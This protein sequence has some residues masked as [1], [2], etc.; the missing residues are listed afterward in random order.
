MTTNSAL[1]IILSCCN[2]IAGASAWQVVLAAR[3]SKL[4]LRLIQET[5]DHCY[6]DLVPCRYNGSVRTDAPGTLPGSVSHCYAWIELCSPLPMPEH[7]QRPCKSIYPGSLP[8]T[9]GSFPLLTGLVQSQ[10]GQSDLS[11]GK[12]YRPSSAAPNLLV[13]SFTQTGLVS[14]SRSRWRGSTSSFYLGR[15]AHTMATA[16]AR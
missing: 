8:G 9:Y 16:S 3:L 7:S 15:I 14:S 6:Q 1:S 10:I 11:D 5:H 13:G 4:L 12:N 2:V